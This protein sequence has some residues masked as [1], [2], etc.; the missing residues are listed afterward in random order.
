M[1]DVSCILHEKTLSKAE[2]FYLDCE[3]TNPKDI[4]NE[5]TFVD[6][7]NFDFAKVNSLLNQKS[8][9]YFLL[10]KKKGCEMKCFGLRFTEDILFKNLLNRK[11]EAHPY[12][13][14]FAR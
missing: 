9:N 11:L 13:L 4:W 6:N 8:K 10:E 3:I 12:L 5:F 2:I 7:S 14:S 1:E